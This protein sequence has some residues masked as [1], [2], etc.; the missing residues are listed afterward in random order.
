MLTWNLNFI[1]ERCNFN[2]GLFVVMRVT[3]THGRQ[4]S[5]GKPTSV[6][7]WQTQEAALEAR[8]GPLMNRNTRNKV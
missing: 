8:F 6:R 4:P 5:S 7:M 1:E 3:C 2:G